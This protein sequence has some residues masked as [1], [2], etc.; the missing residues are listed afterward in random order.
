[1]LKGKGKNYRP[2]IDGHSTNKEI[3]NF[4]AESYKTVFNFNDVGYDKAAMSELLKDITDDISGNCVYATSCGSHIISR[5]GIVNSVKQMRPGKNDGF[6]GLSSDYILNAPMSL[7]EI[8]SVLFTCMLHHLDSFYLSTMVP[9]PKGSNKDLSMS[10][11]YRCIALSSIFSKIF[12][13]CIISDQC[14]ALNSDD[15]QFAYKSGCS[16]TQCVSVLCETIDYY[17]HNESDVYMCS[18][19]ASKAFDR[20]KILLMFRKL[21]KR[22]FCSY[23]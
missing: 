3:A 4:F 5:D 19:D 7:F 12:D 13:N 9:I 11:N 18:I 22:N 16:T 2:V 10:K 20:V 21:G 14:L 1:M 6:D 15:L 8:L 17:V 23:F